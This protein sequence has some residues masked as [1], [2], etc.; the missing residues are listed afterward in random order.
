VETGD[1]WFAPPEDIARRALAHHD[2]FRV[3]D[4]ADLVP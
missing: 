2:P 1:A 3:D 4:L